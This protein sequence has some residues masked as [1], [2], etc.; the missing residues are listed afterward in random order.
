MLGMLGAAARRGLRRACTHR[1]TGVKPLTSLQIC[2]V[3]RSRGSA[4]GSSAWLEPRAVTGWRKRARRS[5]VAAKCLISLK[6]TGGQ[7]SILS[8]VGADLAGR[9]V[10]RR[11]AGQLER[12]INEIN[13]LG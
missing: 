13:G 11:R 8:T 6:T 9:G 2:G 5:Q 7:V 10:G 1:P 3:A 12:K 4:Q